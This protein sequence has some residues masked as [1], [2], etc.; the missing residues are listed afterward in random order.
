MTAEYNFYTIQ[1]GGGRPMEFEFDPD[2]SRSNRTK[3][4][5]DVVHSQNLWRD[6]S[7][8][9]IPAAPKASRGGWSSASS[10][11]STGRP[12]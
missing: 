1:P 12:W 11:A 9:E 10:T 5:I 2:K 6:P 8:V 4:G 7:R 3:H